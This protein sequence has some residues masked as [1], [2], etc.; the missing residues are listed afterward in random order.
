MVEKIFWFIKII[1]NIKVNYLKEQIVSFFFCLN[2]IVA[3]LSKW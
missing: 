1:M 2:I 3:A